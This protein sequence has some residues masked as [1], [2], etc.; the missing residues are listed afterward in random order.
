MRDYLAV[1]KALSDAGRV[2]L[3]HALRDGELCVCQLIELLQLAPSTV[4][5][6]LSILSQAN[7]VESR[8]KGRWVYYR[9]PRKAGSSI[10]SRIT[11]ETFS[12]LQHST[13][14]KADQKRM[15]AIRAID[16]ETRCR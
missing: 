4:S 8:K 12:H 1:T 11:R 10:A 3:L 13:E 14:L 15:K 16:P 2:R 6:H 5:K 9:L 7:L